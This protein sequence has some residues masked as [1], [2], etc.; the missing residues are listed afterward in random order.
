MKYK[1]KMS[2]RKFLGTASCA[3]VGTTTLFS[4]LFNLGMANSLAGASLANSNTGDYRAM[5]CILLGGGNDS[6]NMLVPRSNSAYNE[7]ANTRSNLALPQGDLLPLNFTGT[8]GKQFGLNSAMPEVQA[9]F[10]NNK[11]AFLSNV[12]TL[13]EPT[14]KSQFLNGTVPL[15]KG[16]LSHSDQQQQWQTSIPQTRSARGWGGKMADILMAGNNNQN[17]SMNISLS[18]TNIF[19]SGQETIEFSIENDATGSVGIAVYEGGDPFTDLLAS[20]TQSLLEQNYQDIFRKT[21]AQKIN[22]SQAGHEQFSTAIQNVSPFATQFAPNDLAQ[23][24]QMIANTIAARDELDMQ[25]QTFFVAF[26]GWDHHDEVLDNQF[27]MLATL[28]NAMNSFQSAMEELGIA[29]CVTT[30]TA[31]DFSRTLTSNGN[32]TDHAWGGNVMV[33][34][35]AVNG[36]QIYGEYPSLNLGSSFDVGGGIILPE[37][38]TDQYFA[39]LAQWFGVEN[40]DLDY[41]LPNIENFY[42]IGSGAPIGFMG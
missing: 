12:G 42:N 25:R 18:G 11:L 23:N 15:P 34:G 21:Y 2:R 37:I 29:D 31:S 24:M 30:F 13:V 3:A 8:N 17:I 1:N 5:V 27:A 19:Q 10:N 35:D 36:G 40:G 14:S 16:L 7:Y 9:L 22:N 41:V 39:E 32:G 6:Y 33:M 28:S 20:G 4:S 38:S 26:N